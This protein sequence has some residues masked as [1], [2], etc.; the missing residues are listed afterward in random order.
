M[1]RCA[2][3]AVSVVLCVAAVT[4]AGPGAQQAG[5]ALFTLVAAER[6]F[7]RMSVATTQR[8]AFL[9]N[10]ADEGVWFAPG[11]VNTKDALRKQPPVTG[12]PRRVLDWDPVTGDVASSGDLG[13]TTGPWIPS[14]PAEGNGPAK[15]VGTGWFFSVWTWRADT[16]WKVLADC[17]VDAPHNL[18]LRGQTFKR[19]AT[20]GQAPGRPGSAAGMATELAT[21]DLDFATRL[22][23]AG[24]ASALGTAGTSDVRIYRDG[25]EPAVGLA[26]AAALPPRPVGPFK[27][28]TV[29]SRA[30]A[31]GDLGVTYGS[32]TAGSGPMIVRGYY[33]HVWKR[34]DG[35]W[36]LAVDVSNVDPPERR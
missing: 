24:W 29:F 30:S 12:A 26:A 13:Y 9:A 28:E 6:A 18:T 27:V 15:K 4:V 32:Y 5:D 25:R 33:L 11:P 2:A 21:A 10:F 7:A 17:G 23:A 14:E 1:N 35:A 36:K 34:V 8:D 31:A 22:D 3:A 20:R 16:G 19:A